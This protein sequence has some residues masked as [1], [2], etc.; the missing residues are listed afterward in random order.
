MKRVGLVLT[1][2][3]VVSFLTGCGG[4]EKKLECVLESNNMK[5]VYT[6]NFDK[7]D[8]FSSAILVQDVTLDENSLKAA[9]LDDYKT[10]I[11]KAWEATEMGSLNHKVTDNGKDTVTLT[12]DFDKKDVKKLAGSDKANIDDLKETLE[13]SNYTCK[14][15]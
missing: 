2:L 3:C 8:N 5:Q 11:N 13:K 6:M 9:S 1:S 12:V 15:K 4:K 14:V 10:Q 7:K